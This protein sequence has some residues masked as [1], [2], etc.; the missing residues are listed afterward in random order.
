MEAG[1]PGSRGTRAPHDRC[2]GGSWRDLDVPQFVACSLRGARP[3]RP[4]QGICAIDAASRLGRGR[5]FVDIGRT[6]RPGQ[7]P[8]ALRS[9]RHW[10]RRE[11]PATAS[12]H[13]AAGNFLRRSRY[14]GAA[15]TAHAAALYRRLAADHQRAPGAATKTA[16][17]AAGA[18]RGEQLHGD[19]PGVLAV[20]LRSIPPEATTQEDERFNVRPSRGTIFSCPTYA[21]LAQRPNVLVLHSLMPSIA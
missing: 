13:P 1:G 18:T 6:V 2:K 12:L 19:L 14:A 7:S 11:C 9:Q 5:Q 17:S 4:R 20:R 3:D 21:R 8:R 16:G 15:R 10:Q